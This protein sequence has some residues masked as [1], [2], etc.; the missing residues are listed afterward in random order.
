MNTPLTLALPIVFSSLM[1]LVAVRAFAS[2]D[3]VS[4]VVQAS[5][6][7]SI[8]ITLSKQATTAIRLGARYAPLGQ[9]P[10]AIADKTGAVI[11]YSVLPSTVTFTC[12][13]ANVR[14]VMECLL[15]SRIDRVCRNPQSGL[16]KLNAA[17]S[18]NT[19]VHHNSGQAEEIWILGSRF[20]RESKMDKV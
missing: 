17:K 8:Q 16:A 9:I 6:S 7:S 5:Q 4:N 2:A 14:Y 1:L 19:F 18:S 11:H 20:G 12:V 15:G 13:G 3:N 10:K